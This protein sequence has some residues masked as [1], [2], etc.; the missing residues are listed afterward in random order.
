MQDPFVMFAL[1]RAYQGAG[2]A[3]KAKTWAN[4]AANANTLPTLPSAFVRMKARNLL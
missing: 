2:D 1:A 4:A 3:A